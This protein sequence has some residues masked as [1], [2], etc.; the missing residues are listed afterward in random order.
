MYHTPDRERGCCGSVAAALQTLRHAH[1]GRV[2]QPFQHVLARLAL[3][4]ATEPVA[5]TS[6]YDDHNR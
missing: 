1:D 4:A 3:C 2:R 5:H 6:T